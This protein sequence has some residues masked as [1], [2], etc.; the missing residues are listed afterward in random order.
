MFDSTKNI[1]GMRRLS[2]KRLIT[3]SGGGMLFYRTAIT[4][5]VNPQ[6]I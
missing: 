2:L 1:A 4:T 3:V 5:V 6:L